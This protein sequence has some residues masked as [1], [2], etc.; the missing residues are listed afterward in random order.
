MRQ[1]HD[2]KNLEQKNRISGAGRTRKPYIIIGIICVVILVTAA[3]LAS[4]RYFDGANEHEVVGG[5]RR[6]IVGHIGKG[7]EA[8]LVG[9]KGEKIT[10]ENE[11]EVDFAQC[12]TT[13]DREHIIAQETDG[14]L[15]LY[16]GQGNNPR[17]IDSDGMFIGERYV[18]DQLMVYYRNINKSLDNL[19]QDSEYE[20]RCYI[21]EQGKPVDFGLCSNGSFTIKD[22]VV[23]FAQKGSVFYFDSTMSAPEKIADGHPADYI[24]F[25]GVSDHAETTVWRV[26][27]G[28]EEKIYCYQD[29]AVQLLGS[30]EPLDSIED[31]HV[32]FFN[33][34]ASMVV[35]GKT[36]MII[37]DSSGIPW[38]LT[39]DGTISDC[40]VVEYEDGWRIYYTVE[41]NDTSALYTVAADRNAVLLKDG[42]ARVWG[43][44]VNGLYFTDSDR[45]L[46]WGA[47][48]TDMG[49]GAGFSVEKILDKVSMALLS[50]TEDTLLILQ[51]ATVDFTTTLSLSYTKTDKLEVVSFPQINNIYMYG[52]TEDETGI[53]YIDRV[54]SDDDGETLVLYY[55]AF[56]GSAAVEIDKKIFL[57][58]VRDGYCYGGPGVTYFKQAFGDDTETYHPGMYTYYDGKKQLISD[59]VSY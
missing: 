52:L 31:V 40:G 9:R 7:G 15:Y 10:L 58:D 24:Q 54:P 19:K 55:Q 14:S 38:E 25:M 20:F 30:M 22:N 29:D 56:D 17:K 13:A 16:D 57:L 21:Y 6:P 28:T 53:Y 2:E 35:Y 39:V 4:I 48:N 45:T 3:I 43:H 47:I 1:N 27:G 32:Q 59:S 51:Y 37:K 41:E 5:K 12:I 49:N 11:A 36:K 26:H 33:N 42:V 8:L 50:G 46:Y 34:G 18:N 23:L 44:S